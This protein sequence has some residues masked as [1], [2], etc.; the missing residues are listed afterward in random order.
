MQK[1]IANKSPTR[2]TIPPVLRSK[3]LAGRPPTNYEDFDYNKYEGRS[4]QRV[5]EKMATPGNFQCTPE[6]AK[7]LKEMNGTMKEATEYCAEIKKAG[8][9]RKGRYHLEI[10]NYFW[11]RPQKKVVRRSHVG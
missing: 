9:T 8:E 2:Q 5:E 1:E 3:R 4:V 10:W 11:S 7:P 6:M